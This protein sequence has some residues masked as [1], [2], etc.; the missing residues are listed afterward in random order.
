MLDVQDIS[1]QI[2]N[3]HLLRGV[4][5][6]FRPGELSVILGPNGSG[7]SSFIKVV[8][9]LIKPGE[10]MVTYDGQEL[11]S[12]SKSFLA[13][14]RA[15]CNQHTAINFSMM[16]EEVVM[17]GRH[18]FF[19]SLPGRKD[20]Q[21]CDEVIRLLDLDSLRGRDYLTLSG[22]EQQRTQLA[23]AMVQLWERPEKGARYLFLD[24]P[25]SSLDIRHQHQLLGIVRRL[26]REGFAIIAVLHDINLALQYADRVMLFKDGKLRYNGL[27]GE[28]ITPVTI[29]EV[30]E[31]PITM[32]TH[33][34]SGRAMAAFGG[35]Q[36]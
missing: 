34:L 10:G 22:G 35:S 21:I 24:E 4:S 9:G 11:S 7:K 19:D 3:K 32:I 17:T 20:Q 28:V 36:A 8:A 12:L 1:L 27:P 2:N 23:R 29:D 31:T 33:P 14:K 26:A 16:L 30:F 25:V 18:P 13:K 6:D 15:V 5:A